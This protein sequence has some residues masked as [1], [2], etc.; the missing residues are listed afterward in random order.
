MGLSK[1]RL[2]PV[3]DGA[4]MG[5]CEGAGHPCRSSVGVQAPDPPASHGPC[6]SGIAHTG[7]AVVAFAGET[8]G[9]DSLA[10][11]VEGKAPLSD[12]RPQAGEG[13]RRGFHGRCLGSPSV[14]GEQKPATVKFG[15]R[16]LLREALLALPATLC[17]PHSPPHLAARG[18]GG[19]GDDEERRPG[20]SDPAALDGADRASW[21]PFP[22]SEALGD[23]RK[24][25]CLFAKLP[26][27]G[28]TSPE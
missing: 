1:R 7:V 27:L 18:L 10:T 16:P 6:A 13:V 12:R 4:R 28:P 14:R 25:L 8:A 22:C 15:G 3:L 21:A 17:P 5:T 19:R 2:C 20:G 23:V 24:G 11:P 26:P 9:G